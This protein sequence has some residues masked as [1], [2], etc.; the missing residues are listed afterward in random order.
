MQTYVIRSLVISR[1]TQIMYRH[2]YQESN[3]GRHT[4]SHL[5]R[6]VNDI[7][8]CNLAFVH[9]VVDLLELGKTDSLVRAV[10][11]TAAVEVERLGCVLAVA[12][13]AALDGDHLDDRLED[14][15]LEVGACRQTDAHDCA[16][17]ANILLYWS[18]HRMHM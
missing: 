10:D 18:Q 13:V 1:T 11:E 3:H 2:P 16:A 17:W 15:S 9:E 14:G 5:L 6:G 7:A 12:H 8:A 4:M